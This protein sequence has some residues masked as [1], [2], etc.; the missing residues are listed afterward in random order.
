MPGLMCAGGGGGKSYILATYVYAPMAGGWDLYPMASVDP[1]YF[2]NFQLL[3][4]SAQADALK[5]FEALLS[6]FIY[7]NVYPTV[8]DNTTGIQTEVKSNNTYIHFEKGILILLVM[9]LV[10]LAVE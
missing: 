10:H 9:V 6:P 3:R 2:G 5:S 1:N 7:A 4:Y 8:I